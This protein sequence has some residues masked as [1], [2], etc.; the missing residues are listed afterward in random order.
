MLAPKSQLVGEWKS[1]VMG[2][3]IP[4]RGLSLEVSELVAAG[5][6]CR[7]PRLARE[8]F[9]AALGVILM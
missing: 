1:G 7:E 2:A 5:C 9:E 8:C 6:S 3:T 4:Y